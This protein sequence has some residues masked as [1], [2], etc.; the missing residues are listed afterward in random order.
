MKKLTPYQQEYRRYL[1]TYSKYPSIMPSF[2]EYLRDKRD[3]AG[4]LKN[5]KEYRRYEDL[6]QE[7]MEGDFYEY[8]QDGPTWDSDPGL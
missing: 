4:R 1:E 8:T 6:I 2:M 7:D 5:W 3:E